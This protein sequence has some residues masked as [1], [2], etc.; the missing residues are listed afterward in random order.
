MSAVSGERK[1]RGAGPV[2]SWSALAGSALTFGAC[3]VLMVLGIAPFRRGLD[4]DTIPA[5]TQAPLG[6]LLA[7]M[8]VAALLF[9][10]PVIAL[11]WQLK[12][13]WGG[14]R[15][16]AFFV[17]APPTLLMIGVKVL[18]AV[19][20]GQDRSPGLIPFQPPAWGYLPNWLEVAGT[21]LSCLFAA[22]V[23]TTLARA[24]RSSKAR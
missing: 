9:G 20:A 2:W 16:F 5:M 3:I 18:M 24:K 19:S 12:R 23:Y 6:E 22:L 15:A 4:G 7:A 10:V 1:I 8:I 13:R 21:A 11:G 14:R 17:A